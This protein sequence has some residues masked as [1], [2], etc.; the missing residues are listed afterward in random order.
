MKVLGIVQA[1]ALVLIAI[2]AVYVA[3]H[4]LI[5]EVRHSG[6]IVVSCP[7]PGIPCPGVP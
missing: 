7:L 4:G 6:G 5:I 1:A 3:T 2:A